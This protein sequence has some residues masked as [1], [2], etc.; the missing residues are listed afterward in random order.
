MTD[1]VNSQITDSITQSNTNV[2]GGS[3]AQSMGLVYQTMAHSI[4][5]AM[6][7]AVATQSAM[8]QINVAVV[9]TTCKKI[10]ELA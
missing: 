8:Q 2:L 3:P 1:T 4:S 7:N 10:V 9:S 5:L 6:Q